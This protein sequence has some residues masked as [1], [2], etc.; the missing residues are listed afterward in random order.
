[1]P[2]LRAVERRRG[3]PQAA[4]PDPVHDERVD[5]LLVD[6]DAERPH[7]RERRLACRRSARSARRASRPRPSAPISSAR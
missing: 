2:A 3:R 4:E 5:V 6:L 1:M 7:D